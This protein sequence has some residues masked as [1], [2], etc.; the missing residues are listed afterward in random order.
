MMLLLHDSLAVTSSAWQDTMP[1]P[2]QTPSHLSCQ[3]KSCALTTQTRKNHSHPGA[4]LGT[5]LGPRRPL[6]LAPPGL[7]RTRTVGKEGSKSNTL[8]LQVN[9]THPTP[10]S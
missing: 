4:R 1:L 5:C 7:C 2:A 3:I 6:C 8:H 10:P 9:S